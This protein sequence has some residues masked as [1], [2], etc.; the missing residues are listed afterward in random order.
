[1]KKLFPAITGLLLIGAYSLPT[2]AASNNDSGLY[3]GGN[4]G[5]VK[6]D[7]QDDFDDDNE[8]YQGLLGYRI[9]PYLGVEGS[10][11]DFGKYG[12]SLA[13]AK[14]DGY[15]AAL[16]LTAPIGDRVDLYAK[17]GQLWYNTDYDIAG[18]SG[19]KDDTAVFAGA[20]VGFKVTDNF[21]VNAEYTWYD[22]DLDVKDVRDGSDTN[23]DF[24][25]VTAG[26]E[27]RF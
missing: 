25:Q 26:V 7:G 21:I 5:Y 23:T 15:T 2:Y 18:A 14:T 3:V 17:G 24:N 13:N 1:M 10:Y 16:K 12:S 9:N 22:V 11:I 8:V 19:D 20:G 27:Y 6:I 4:V